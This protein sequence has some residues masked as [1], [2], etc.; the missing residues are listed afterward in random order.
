MESISFFKST[1]LKPF[2][3]LTAKPLVIVTLLISVILIMSLTYK[4]H[5]VNRENILYIPES[6]LNLGEVWENSNFTWK[7]PIT[8]R[9]NKVVEVTKFRATCVCTQVEPKSL[10][11]SPGET[12][13]IQLKL[14][15]SP[16]KPEDFGSEVRNFGVA[17]FPEI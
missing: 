2:F 8:N 1:I 6:A 4:N 11:L 12:R 13:E 3:R 5:Q 16:K 9:G 10:F 17:I 7:L 14:N 15:L